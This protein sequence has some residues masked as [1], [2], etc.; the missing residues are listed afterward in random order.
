[1]DFKH[2]VEA[3][4]AHVSLPPG[5]SIRAWSEADFA[6]IQRLS[7]AEGWPTPN[8]RP[9]ESLTS[10]RNAWPTLVATDGEA[11]IGFVRALTDGEITMYIAELLVVPERR[12][13]G[14]GRALL[15][16]CH[17]LYPHTRLDLLSTVSS[18][19]FYE[20]FGF[21]RFQG[22]RKSYQ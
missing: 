2:Q 13:Q 22:F 20:G 1:M 8:E 7:A 16:V 4:F 10:W 17:H 5:V 9:E 11:V 6:G 19:G 12:G 15:D 3:A 18:D 21:R 14:L